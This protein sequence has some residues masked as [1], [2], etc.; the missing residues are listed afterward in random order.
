MR[1]VNNVTKNQVIALCVLMAIFYILTNVF[2]N[3]QAYFMEMIQTK[4]ILYVQTVI[5][6]VQTVLDLIT[7]NAVHVNIITLT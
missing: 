4:V 7:L 2:K 1:V 3:A 5:I 6:G